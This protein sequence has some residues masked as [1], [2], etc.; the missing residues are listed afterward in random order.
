MFSCIVMK[1]QDDNYKDSAVIIDG[2]V[3]DYISDEEEDQPKKYF[4]NKT[5]YDSLRFQIRTIPD[6]V[7]KSLHADDEFWYANG[8]A[9][10][11]DRRT[12][13]KREVKNGTQND[14]EVRPEKVEKKNSS[15][16]PVSERGWFQSLMWII[17]VGGFAIALIWYLA[18][19]NVSLFRKKNKKVNETQEDEMPVDIFAINYQKEI[20]KAAAGGN[21]RMAI[22]LMYLRLLKNLSE[23]NIIQYKQDRTNLDYLMQ[24]HPTRYYNGFFRITRNYEY[25]WYGE[26]PVSNEA[27]GIIKK[28]FDNFENTAG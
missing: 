19:S 6:S 12:Q 3:R 5:E 1:A 23:R 8:N 27:Y 13:P 9:E 10:K 11:G 17:I 2:T 16:V 18:G 14:K 26:F 4:L 28:E 15:Y 21:Y 7:L 25:S 20:D 24:L 22:R